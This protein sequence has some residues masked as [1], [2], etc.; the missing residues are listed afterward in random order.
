MCL[1]TEPTQTH[2]LTPVTRM[3]DFYVD[4]EPLEDVLAAYE[5]AEKDVTAVPPGVFD[6]LAAELE[7]PATPNEK[8]REAVQHPRRFSWI[9]R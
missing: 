9:S 5:Q 3:D 7:T 4:D 2:T 6:R 8:L 1:P